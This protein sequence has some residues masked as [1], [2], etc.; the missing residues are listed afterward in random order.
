MALG[1]VI[2]SLDN[3]QLAGFKMLL[4]PT[5]PPVVET[6]SPSVTTNCVTGVVLLMV[7]PSRSWLM[8]PVLPSM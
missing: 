6:F 1:C 3:D 2:P 5:A 4:V 8:L 7:S